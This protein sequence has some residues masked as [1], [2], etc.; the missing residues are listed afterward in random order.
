ML[1]DYV[2]GWRE[3]VAHLTLLCP[4]GD[5]QGPCADEGMIGLDLRPAV[6]CVLQGCSASHSKERPQGATWVVT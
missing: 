5:S 3:P 2:P 6:L 4:V 1:Q